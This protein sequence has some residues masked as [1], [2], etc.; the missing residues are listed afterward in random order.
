MKTLTT[1]KTRRKS[2][3]RVRFIVAYGNDDCRVY[4]LPHSRASRRKL[5]AALDV[6]T[7]AF[8]KSFSA[9][10]GEAEC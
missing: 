9:A 2:R 5:E 10:L 4:E 3:P 1:K 8:A 6:A 7:R